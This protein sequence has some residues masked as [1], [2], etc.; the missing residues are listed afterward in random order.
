LTVPLEKLITEAALAELAGKRSFERGVAYFEDGA[1]LSF[2]Q[3]GS[4]VK[5]RVLG[6]EE[7]RVSLRAEGSGLGWSCTCPLGD[8][9]EFCK[10]A[11]AAGL[12]WLAR[13]GTDEAPGRDADDDL[14]RIRAYLE[15][16]SKKALVELLLD[17][18]A[19]E[20]DLHA[21][22]ETMALRTDPRVDPKALTA[23]V[24]RAFAISGGFVDWKSMRALIQRADSVRDMLE[25]LLRDG[26]AEDAAALADYAMHRGIAA[27]HDCDDSG[28]GFG[29]TLRGIAA[30]HLEA[31]RRAKPDQKS[32]GEKLF[33]LHRVDGWGFFAL[34]DYV[35]LL[36]TR[37][38]ARYRSLAESAWRNVAPLRPGDKDK[39]DGE[40]FWI[41]HI[42]E[43]LA[44]HE[45]D[46]DAL[47]AVKS[48][49]LSRSWAFL[50]IAQLLAK[51]GR[52]Q[53]A[54]EWAERGWKSFPGEMKEPL[55]D[56]L[57]DAY[58]EQ[59]RHGDAVQVAWDEFAS[60]SSLSGYQ[61]LRKCAKADRH[62]PSWR[63]K[64]LEHVR[65]ELREAGA[66]RSAR[67]WTAG[68]R[69]P[70]VEIFLDEGDTDAALG[71]AKAG[72]CT[73]QLWLQIARARAATHPQDA[74]GIY[75]AH[76]ER[77]VERA[78]NHAYD[79][80]AGLA[81]TIRE[82]MSRSGGEAAFPGW[83]T[84]L[85]AKHKAKRNFVKRLDSIGAQ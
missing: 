53:E 59:R 12:A 44:R 39:R 41:T 42:M 49:D 67:H 6:I 85:K 84:A 75:Q 24:R 33:A 61:R 31:C 83:I 18:A 20:P 4:T 55:V 68:G 21:R 19:E 7:Y 69:S 73:V 14:A 52:A 3:V 64:A 51:T 10:H 70:L 43:S 76:V 82:L 27:Y 25:G 29:D 8:E 35:P 58:L 15:P 60:G 40:R 56:F 78:N 66:S 38:L 2:N 5:A 13:K 79:E 71:E 16:Q 9:G 63:D 34:A 80:A 37:G 47:I 48:R 11:V 36:G 74:I 1:V 46:V 30:V 77:L 57:I 62:W 72:G 50:E 17:A 28:G 23:L 26:R 45:G 54:I 32:L 22:I 65:A 81:G